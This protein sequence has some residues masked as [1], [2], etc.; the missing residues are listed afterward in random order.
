MGA[1]RAVPARRARHLRRPRGADPARVPAWC[2]RR[3]LGPRRELPRRGRRARARA[4]RGERRTRRRA[5]RVAPGAAVPR[6]VEDRAR[7][8]A[9]SPCAEA[10]GLRCAGCATTSSPRSS[11]SW[12]N[13]SDSRRRVGRD[14]REHRVPPGAPRGGR[15]RRRGAR[16]ARG[17]LDLEGD[18]RR[19]AAVLDGGGGRARA[20]EHRVPR[21]TRPAVLPPGRLPLPR[22]D[23]GGPRRSSRSAARCRTRS[24]CR[25]SASTP[26]S[27]RGL[28]VDD[29]LGATCCWSDGVA[30]PPAVARELL[31]R[32][33]EL[34]VEV[35]EHTPAE[36]VERDVLVI[37][38]GPWSPELA[39][40]VGVELPIRP[41][42]RQ[43]L[44][45][46]PLPGCPTTCRWWSRRRRAST[47]AAA[48][49]GSSSR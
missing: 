25:S 6:G 35:R 9:A 46:S 36:S 47:S 24:A 49:T 4:D 1:L 40:T 21:S 7:R 19:A 3:G 41:L 26:R 30:D 13:G 15:R 16:R 43:L 39:R 11:A 2:G 27:S 48:A 8:C 31:R 34:G 28:A 5:A 29:V 12:A 17:R 10:Y 45:T 32:A 44:E 42:C 14:R 33:E 20:G 38:C 37:A 18:G 23:G 22:D